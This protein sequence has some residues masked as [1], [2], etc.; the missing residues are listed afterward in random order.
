MSYRYSS[1]ASAH[2]RDLRTQL[3]SAPNGLTKPPSRV[4]SPYDKAASPSAKHNESFLLSLESQNN[5]EID[6]MT[7]KVSMIKNLGV[8]MGTEINKSIKLNDNITDNMERGKVTLKNTY[9]RMV[10]MS[11]RAG[12]S[13]KLW[14]LVFFIVFLWFFWVWIT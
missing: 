6:S 12:I 13:C 7:E 10:V 3:F 11:E 8:R 4:G 9:N 2:Q 1:N 5:D 14:F